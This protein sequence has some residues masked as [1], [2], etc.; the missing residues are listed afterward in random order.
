MNISQNLR[1]ILESG[2]VENSGIL[3][4]IF[5]NI[6]LKMLK[7]EGGME[8][9]PKLLMLCKNLIRMAFLSPPQNICMVTYTHTHTHT[10]TQFW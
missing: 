4:L 8:N 9:P 3:A 2:K 7:S 10:H 1:L 5:H 6:K